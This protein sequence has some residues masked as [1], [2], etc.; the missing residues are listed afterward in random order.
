MTPSPLSAGCTARAKAS[1]QGAASSFWSTD[2]SAELHRCS[3]GARHRRARTGGMFHVKHVDSR[4]PAAPPTLVPPDA[5]AAI[6]GERLAV[7]ERYAELLATAGV[8]WGLLG[9]REVDR[10]WDRHLLN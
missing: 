6:F 9:P 8:E 10:I 2:R 4:D 3:S 7:A 1:S 5:A